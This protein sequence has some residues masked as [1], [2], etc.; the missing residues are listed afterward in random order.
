M[1]VVGDGES[2]LALLLGNGHTKREDFDAV[3]LDVMLP[4]KDG[5]SLRKNCAKLSITY[6]FSCLRP[7]VDRKMC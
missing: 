3:V 7:E 6:L 4:G 2:A 1:R 5:F